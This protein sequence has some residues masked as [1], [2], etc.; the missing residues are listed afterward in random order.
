MRDV[1]WWLMALAFVLGLLLTLAMMI[2]RVTREVPVTHTVSAGV[3]APQVGKPDL[4][5]D[6]GKVAGAVTA[7]SSPGS[8]GWTRCPPGRACCWRRS[9]PSESSRR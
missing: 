4:K 2:R 8:P 3:G 1:N 9:S 6:L 5:A 7:A